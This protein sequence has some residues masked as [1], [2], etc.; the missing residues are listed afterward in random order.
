[1]KMLENAPWYSAPDLDEMPIA[2][3]M[4]IFQIYEDT[5]TFGKALI[6]EIGGKVLVVHPAH[7][8]ETLRGAWRIELFQKKGDP[9]RIYGRIADDDLL[10]AEI[11]GALFLDRK[12]C[13]GNLETARKIRAAGRLIRNP[14]ACGYPMRDWHDHGMNDRTT[15]FNLLPNDPAA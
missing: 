15:K 7:D 1:M 11:A 13:C 2:E 14:N 12:P 10:Y 8:D 4:R 9:D 6:K 5:Q 3:V